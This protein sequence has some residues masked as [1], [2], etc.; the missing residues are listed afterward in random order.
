MKRLAL[1]LVLMCSQAHAD[2]DL[3][4]Q[5]E[6]LA[7]AGD[8]SRA[9][10]A[11]KAADKQ[12]PTTRNACMIGLAYL[13]RE[14]WPQAELFLAECKQRASATDPAPDWLATS[15]TQLAEKLAAANV[16]AVAIEVTPVSD[17][18]VTV[19]S[20]ALDESFV[21]PHTLHLAPG[22]HT[23]E[24][25]VDGYDLASKTI[26]IPDKQPIQVHIEL[27][28]TGTRAQLPPPVPPAPA[29]SKTPYIVMGAGA[30]LGLGAIA[31]GLVVVRPMQTRL[32]DTRNRDIY[33]KERDRF[34]PRRN[35]TFVAVGVAIATIVTGAILRYTVFSAEAPVQVGLVPTEGGG[36]VTFAFDR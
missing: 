9:I 27:V 21:A 30:A 4:A 24:V 26:T 31:Y 8:F 33:N 34:L 36:V 23:F 17:A 19:S 1:L 2:D 12:K 3:A 13:R 6:A 15:E 22:R 14:A 28:P 18:R 35:L 29:A 25:R 10:D 16:A 7:K 20:F 11:F 5:G 32:A